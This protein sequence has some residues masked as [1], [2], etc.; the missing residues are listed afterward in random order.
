MNRATLPSSQVH[1]SGVHD[2]ERFLCDFPCCG[3]SF[4]TRSSLNAPT[5]PPR[6][7]PAFPPRTRIY[8]RHVAAAVMPTQN[9]PRDSAR[10]SR[11]TRA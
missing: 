11:E 6:P 9:E 5:S 7:L 10:H 2:G 8:S 1:K 3:K 4:T